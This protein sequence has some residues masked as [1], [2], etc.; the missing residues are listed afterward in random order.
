MNL[1]FKR[2]FRKILAKENEKL[3]KCLQLKRPHKLKTS[4]LVV[5]IYNEAERENKT[6]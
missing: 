5:Q 4:K 3:L 2:T 6:R 1:V